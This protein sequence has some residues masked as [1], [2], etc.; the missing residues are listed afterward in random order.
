VGDGAVLTI[1]AHGVILAPSPPPGKSILWTSR[2]VRQF[3][4][5]ES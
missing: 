3:V 1:R 4:D 2:P 5:L